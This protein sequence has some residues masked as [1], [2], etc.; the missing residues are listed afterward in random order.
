MVG[1]RLV[2]AVADEPADRE[3]DLGLA[4]QPPV[5]DDAEQEAREHQ[6]HGHLGIDARPSGRGVVELGHLLVQPAESR[7]RG[8]P[9][10]GHDRRAAGHA[11]S[12]QRT[13]PP[14][15]AP[16]DPTSRRS[17]AASY[18]VWK[19]RIIDSQPFSTAPR[20][21][22]MRNALAHAGEER[23]ARGLGVHRHRLRPGRRRRAAKPSGASRRPGARASCP[24]SP[25]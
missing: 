11:A 13:A 8:R 21:H 10:P 12:R 18:N 1:Q 24:S 19:Q 22:F 20:V 5:V 2:Q 6:P 9:G 7:E 25:P 14:A 3:V 16:C 15:C 17:L 23:P 4:H